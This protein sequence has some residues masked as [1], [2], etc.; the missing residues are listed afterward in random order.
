MP[1]CPRCGK[2]IN[3]LYLYGKQI[4]LFR[5]WF[6]EDLQHE[7]VN[8]SSDMESKEY[9]CPECGETLFTS[10][11]EATEFLKPKA[12]QTTLPIEG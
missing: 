4:Q 9:D 12:K 6:D 2:E 1:K 8:A 5:V 3:E 10:E 11:E 7:W